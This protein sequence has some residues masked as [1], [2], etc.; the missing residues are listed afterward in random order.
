MAE[1]N[2]QRYERTFEVGEHAD[3]T[4]RNVRGGIDITGWDRPAISVT[5]VKKMGTEWGAHESFAETIIDMEQNGAHVRVA[6]RRPGGGLFSWFGVG[7]TPPQVFYTI[8]VPA[9]CDVSVR[10][11]DG[12]LVIGD[13][14]G[15]VYGRTVG[16]AITLSRVSGQIILS[17]VDATVQGIEL[18]GTL[19]CKTVSGDIKVSGSELTSFWSK[20]VSGAVRLETSIDPTGRYEVG[21]VDGSFTLLIPPDS[22]AMVEVSAVSGDATCDIPCRVLE[23]SRQHWRASINGGGATISLKTVSGD[24]RIMPA[25]TPLAAAAAPSATVSTLP[26]D[27]DW[28]EISVLKAVE[29]GELTV[30]QALARLADLD[31]G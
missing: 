9:T 12:T 23:Q 24:L 14:L 18:G 27:R 3:L 10:T 20:A 4:L 8:K 13:V 19:A 29:R 7:R 21:S 5:A 22:R 16:G 15:S 1:Q 28:P 26:A 6:T 25:S 11:V 30:E 31:K 2:E 17:A